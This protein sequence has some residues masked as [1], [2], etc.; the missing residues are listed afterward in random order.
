MADTENANSEMNKEKNDASYQYFNNVQQPV[1]LDQNIN[2]SNILFNSATKAYTVPY[3]T[4]NTYNIINSHNPTPLYISSQNSNE[5]FGNFNPYF[6]LNSS[7]HFSQNLL[8]QTKIENKKSDN[9]IDFAKKFSKIY[10]SY[11]DKSVPH[12]WGRWITT[13]VLY[14]VFALRIITTS[15]WYIVTYALGIYLLNLLI[16]F[17]SPKIDPSGNAY[18]NYY[19]DDDTLLSNYYQ[20]DSHYSNSNQSSLPTK[21]DDEFKPFIRRLPEFKFWLS[22]TQAVLISFFC[23][24][25]EAFDVPV[26]WPILVMY[27]IVLFVL[28]MKRQIAHMIRYKYLPFSHGKRRYHNSLPPN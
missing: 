13:F 28:T 11:L 6:P 25:F 19:F 16:A 14:C 12:T 21:S 17:L 7:T 1:T 5:Q 9:L 23:T 26:F 3:S 18:S 22:A 15:G 10:Q 4:I 24:L 8:K 27:F 2:P 20:D